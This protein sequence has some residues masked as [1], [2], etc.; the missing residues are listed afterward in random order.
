MTI[1]PILAT[2]V[3]LIGGLILLGQSGQPTIGSFASAQQADSGSNSPDSTPGKVHSHSHQKVH[4]AESHTHK[5]L[6]STK[7]PRNA[8]KALRIAK[9][10]VAKARARAA[11]ATLLHGQ[12]NADLKQW[13]QEISDPEV[14]IR[15]LQILL[16]NRRAVL[17][18][19]MKVLVNEAEGMGFPARRRGKRRF[20]RDRFG[21]VA[22]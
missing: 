12:I 19:Q 2:S 17:D 8:I 3:G 22:H 7:E 11:F 13:E 14:S 21:R 4:S 15:K 1:R 10:P 9:D 6:D 5:E 18:L 16:K 20:D